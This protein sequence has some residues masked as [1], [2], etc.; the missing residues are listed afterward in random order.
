M[1]NTILLRRAIYNDDPVAFRQAYDSL[2][3]TTKRYESW[4]ETAINIGSWNVVDEMLSIPD[5]RQDII[6]IDPMESRIVALL[7]SYGNFIHTP[8]STDDVVRI[9]SQFSSLNSIERIVVRLG[10]A[11]YINDVTIAALVNHY[12]D[13]DEIVEMLQPFITDIN[14]VRT[15]LDDEIVDI[16][17]GIDEYEN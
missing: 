9:V 8:K 10:R 11:N 14:T 15:L 4:V 12:K 17:G 7:L 1:A 6:G 5:I 2:T 13:T 3:N 16:F